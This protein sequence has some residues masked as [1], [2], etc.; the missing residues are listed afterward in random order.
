MLLS[1]LKIIREFFPFG[2]SILFYI[3]IGVKSFLWIVPVAQKTAKIYLRMTSI[4]RS[5]LMSKFWQSGCE[6]TFCPNKSIFKRKF[7]DFTL[8][9]VVTSGKDLFKVNIKN[10]L[11][12]PLNTRSKL[13]VHKNVEESCSSYACSIHAQCPR[14]LNV[15]KVNNNMQRTFR[16]LLSFFC[17]MTLRKFLVLG[18]DL[19]VINSSASVIFFFTN[20][21]NHFKGNVAIIWKRD[22]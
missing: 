6:I 5:F 11:M 13:N 22:L 17:W 21:F 20:S 2:C 4:T 9:E 14:A 18:W 7:I 15:I 1:G 10:R 16:V 3:G 8:A 12:H 19:R